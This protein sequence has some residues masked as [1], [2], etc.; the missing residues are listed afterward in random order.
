MKIL[1]SAILP[2][3][4]L[5]NIAYMACIVQYK[6]ITIELHEHFVK[7][8]YRN[9]STIYDANGKLDLIVPLRKWK[10]NTPVQDI[11]IAYDSPWQKLHWRSI[12]TA[13]RSSPYFEFYEDR[14]LPFYSEK[15]YHHLHEFNRELLQ[16]LLTLLGINPTIRYSSAYSPDLDEHVNF[17]SRFTPKRPSQLSMPR[18]P[19]VFETKH[20]FINNLS[21]LDLLFNEGPQALFHLKSLQVS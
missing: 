1:S 19:Q 11:V 12:T 20:G 14:F 17:L 18:Y 13:Y 15:K 9:R 5:G 3:S 2:T 21:I 7:Q 8:T 10:N 16:E 4:Y 6:N